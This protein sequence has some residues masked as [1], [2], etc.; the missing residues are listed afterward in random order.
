MLKDLETKYASLIEKLSKDKKRLSGF[1]KT[2]GYKEFAIAIALYSFVTFLTYQIT[3]DGGVTLIAGSIGLLFFM[4]V[5]FWNQYL[6]KK[7]WNINNAAKYPL[8]TTLAEEFSKSTSWD[9]KYERLLKELPQDIS[10]NEFTYMIEVTTGLIVA[11]L[12]LD[13]CIV[14][15]DGNHT[16]Y[17]F[18]FGYY[19]SDDNDFIY[20]GEKF[21]SNFK[22]SNI[23][24]DYVYGGEGFIINLNRSID[25]YLF[26]SSDTLEKKGGFVGK[27]TQKAIQTAIPNGNKLITMDNPEFE[28]YFSVRGEDKVL[29]H[30]ILTPT[31]MEN[32]VNLAKLHDVTTYISFYKQWMFVAMDTKHNKFELSLQKGEIL[33]E[34]QRF[35]KEFSNVLETV[36]TIDLNM[37]E[38]NIHA[39]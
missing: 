19:H 28:K 26:I 13:D 27:G 29:A 23:Y 14:G 39:K 17:Y 10:E 20:S 11:D 24:D 36:E 5:G 3:Y 12:V 33:D 6:I 8:M 31:F 1:T 38:I 22:T 37:H 35:H 2:W 4:F 34:I 21:L 9:L 25:G 30:Y 18:N 15:K 7:L 16:F 32:L